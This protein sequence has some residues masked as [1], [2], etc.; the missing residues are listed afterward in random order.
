MRLENSSSLASLHFPDLSVE[1]EAAEEEIAVSA[2]TFGA[3][4]ISKAETLLT[5]SESQVPADGSKLKLHS[6]ALIVGA[7]GEGNEISTTDTIVSL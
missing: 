7:T 4:L 1:V 6:L 3:A 2:F 5:I